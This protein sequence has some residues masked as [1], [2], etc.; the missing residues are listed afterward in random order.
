MNAETKLAFKLFE[1]Y[2]GL[3]D[4]YPDPAPITVDQAR[5]IAFMSSDEFIAFFDLCRA[6]RKQ[7]VPA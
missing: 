2:H 5:R 3:A 1:L 4:E 6:A 7:A